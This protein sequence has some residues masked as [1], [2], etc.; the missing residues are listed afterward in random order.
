MRD[1]LNN[2]A[3]F[4]VLLTGWIG[5]GGNASAEPLVTLNEAWL[6]SSLSPSGEDFQ[7]DFETPA[8]PVLGRTAS[9]E[10]SGGTAFALPGQ[11]VVDLP[12]RC[13][14]EFK[15]VRIGD[16]VIKRWRYGA[17]KGRTR[18]IVDLNSK[19]T[20]R[21]VASSNEIGNHFAVRFDLGEGDLLPAKFE[22]RPLPKLE[23][24]EKPVRMDALELYDQFKA[25]TQDLVRDR[26]TVK[27]TRV[28]V[29]P[30]AEEGRA[31][32]RLLVD[33]DPDSHDGIG[34]IG[35][36][37]RISLVVLV[38]LAFLASVGWGTSRPVSLRRAADSPE[39]APRVSR[40]QLAIHYQILNLSEQASNAEIKSRYRELAKQ[41]HSDTF[42]GG[43]RGER[44]GKIANERFR[45]IDEAYRALKAARGID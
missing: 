23:R 41:F 42:A 9:S 25:S 12:F 22:T 13:E 40:R 26:E 8:G 4:L 36:G 44:S 18:V 27:N 6:Y 24:P 30:S 2:V 11:L 35:L 20:P 5:A 37:M 21:F 32:E 3:L 15:D 10:L 38:G 45:Q 39:G 19:K 14:T 16:P 28:V 33:T 29:A 34:L 7:L 17:R 43:A 1:S 31:L